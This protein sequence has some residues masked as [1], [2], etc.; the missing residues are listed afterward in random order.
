MTLLPA[1]NSEVPPS[2]GSCR[3][4]FWRARNI[5]RANPSC[6]TRR[7]QGAFGLE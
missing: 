6:F 2:V 7:R 3:R 4:N 5:V 1:H